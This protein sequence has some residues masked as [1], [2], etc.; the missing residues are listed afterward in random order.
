MKRRNW[1][2]A[3]VVA[4]AIGVAGVAQAGGGSGCNFRG[5]H[6][7]DGMMY[8]MKNLDLSKEQRQAIRDIKKDSRDKME[9]KRDEMFDIRKELHE[10]VNSENYDAAKVRKLAD[11]KAKIMSDLA[12]Q[13]IETMQRV[14]KE[15]TAEQRE[16]LDDVKDY[17]FGR[18]RH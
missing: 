5:D 16:K 10:Q 3:S 15:L 4:G 13:N 11:A 18:G 1:I 8:M 14:Q 9:A 17:R 12:V 7:G 2:I 6:R